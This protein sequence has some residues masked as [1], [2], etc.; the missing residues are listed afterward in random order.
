[1][2]LCNTIGDQD[3]EPCN[4]FFSPHQQQF[5]ALYGPFSVQDVGRVEQ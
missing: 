1:M 5:I 3:V 2:V 4:F